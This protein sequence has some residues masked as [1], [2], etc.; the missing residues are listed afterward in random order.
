M[1]H[2]ID[3]DKSGEA[4]IVVLT[5]SCVYRD[6]FNIFFTLQQRSKICY[7]VKIHLTLNFELSVLTSLLV[8]L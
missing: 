7:K 2:F 3:I 4:H 6:T 1:F 8:S 5:E